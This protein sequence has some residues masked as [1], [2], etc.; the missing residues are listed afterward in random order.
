[1]VSEGFYLKQNTPL[2][3]HR[4]QTPESFT[5][6]GSGVLL[7]RVKISWVRKDKVRLAVFSLQKQND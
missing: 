3:H 6:E 7:W 4:E 2:A 1:M 5:D